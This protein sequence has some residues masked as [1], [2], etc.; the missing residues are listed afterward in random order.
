MTHGV[1][2]LI[3]AGALGCW[4]ELMQISSRVRRS[5]HDFAYYFVLW[6]VC[7][8]AGFCLASGAMWCMFGEPQKL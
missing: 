6:S 4:A 3:A 5:K 7:A 1:A 8:T 2:L